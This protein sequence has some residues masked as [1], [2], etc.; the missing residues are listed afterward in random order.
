[1]KNNDQPIGALWIKKSKAGVEYL[2][3]NLDFGPLFSRINI[4]AFRNDQKK[5][6]QPDF[7]ILLSK[8]QVKNLPDEEDPF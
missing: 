5:E 4:V 7:R 8:P 2:S 6:G 3:G 1:M